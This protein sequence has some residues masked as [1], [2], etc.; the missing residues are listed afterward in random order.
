ML[1]TKELHEKILYPCVRIRAKGIAGSGTVIYSR[2]MPDNGDGDYE[3]YILTNHHVVAQLIDVKKQFDP[4]VKRKIDKEFLA[5]AE[6]TVFEYVWLSHVDSGST[7]RGDVIA[8]DENHD[9]AVLKLDSPLPAKHVAALYPKGQEKKINLFNPVWVAGCSLAHDPICNSGVLTYLEERIDNKLF[10]MNNANMIF[11]NCLPAGS[12]VSLANGTIRPIEHVEPGDRVWATSSEGLSKAT[13]EQVIE[14]GTK[15]ILEIKTRTRTLRASGNHP[16]L[17]LRIC[18]DWKGRNVN[19]ADWVQV[20]ELSEGDVIAVLPGLPDRTRVYG[21]N[22][23]SVVGQDK[24]RLEVMRFLGFY[25]GDGWMRIHPSMSYEV[26]LAVYDERLQDEY[27]AIMQRLFGKQPTVDGGTL[28]LY[29][30][31]ATEIIE[32]LGL[33]GSA[34]EKTVPDWVMTAP[35][36]EQLMFLTGYLEADGYINGVGAWVFEAN[37][38]EMIARLRMM[39]IHLGFNVSNLHTRMRMPVEVNG[40]IAVPNA[41]SCSFQVYPQYTKSRSTHIIGDISQLPSHLEWERVSSIK[42]VGEQSTY[43]L[44]ITGY[45]N[46]FADGV[47]VHNSGGSLYLAETGEL[48]GVP[49]RVTGLQLGFGVDIITWM[50]FVVPIVRI[51]EFLD[52]Q[53][54]HFLYDEGYTSTQCFE[55]RE[56]KK[57]EALLTMRGEPEEE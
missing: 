39:C 44:K 21:V 5:Q 34:T 35:H 15:T 41:P 27:T 51:Y 19:Y 18:Q 24:D 8:Y 30:K 43:D 52:E 33:T 16:L 26:S 53:L 47:L 25:L 17:A 36:E 9:L 28:H 40:R 13:V 22:L 57:K 38:P 14:S 29:D 42:Y 10:W 48:I 31:R 12:L 49:A 7:Y 54:L 6:V 32:E 56:Q 37:N 45:Y 55:M 3:T 4:L 46:F 50:G 23:T 20:D 1:S 11:G 2:P